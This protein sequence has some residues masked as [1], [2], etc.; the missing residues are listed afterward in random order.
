[1]LPLTQGGTTSAFDHDMLLLTVETV[2]TT[3]LSRQLQ[4]TVST[5]MLPT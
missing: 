4:M 1:M 3:E 2:I 5:N